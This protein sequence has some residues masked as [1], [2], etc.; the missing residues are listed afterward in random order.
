MSMSKVVMI[1]IM[2]TVMEMMLIMLVMKATLAWKKY[3]TAGA[4]GV[5]YMLCERDSDNAYESNGA[6]ALC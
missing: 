1:V 4:G 5:D 2:M 6:K 3:T